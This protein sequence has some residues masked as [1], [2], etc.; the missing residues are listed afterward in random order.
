M[1]F[2]LYLTFFLHTELKTTEDDGIG[3]YHRQLADTR[4]QIVQDID[5][6]I[7]C[8]SKEPYKTTADQKGWLNQVKAIPAPSEGN[9]RSFKRQGPS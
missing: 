2:F 4:D 1:G 3:D 7:F 8:Y 6:L 5:K 9:I